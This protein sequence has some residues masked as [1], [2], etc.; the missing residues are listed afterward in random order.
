MTMNCFVLIISLFYEILQM[1]ETVS[2]LAP[3]R[4]EHIPTIVQT[5]LASFSG[6]FSSFL[7]PSLPV[8]LLCWN[9]G[10]SRRDRPCLSQYI[11]ASGWVRGCLLQSSRVLFKAPQT[12]LSEICLSLCRFH[13]PQNNCHRQ[14]RQ[15]TFSFG[16]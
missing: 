2:P 12:G 4:P 8:S 9:I 10:G 13:Y 15:R 16:R 7:G 1:N 11:S 14:N 6:F 5:H 3:M